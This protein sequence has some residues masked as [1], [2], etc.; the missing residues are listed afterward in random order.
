MKKLAHK[1]LKKAKAFLIQKITK[2]LKAL[3]LDDPK[4]L[5]KEETMALVKK[6]DLELYSSRHFWDSLEADEYV[7][8][9][10]ADLLD[11]P[12]EVNAEL[13]KMLQ[14]ASLKKSKVDL[15]EQMKAF[16]QKLYHDNTTKDNNLDEVKQDQKISNDSFFVTSLNADN[17]DTKKTKSKRKNADLYNESDDEDTAFPVHKKKNRP[18]QR[19]RRELWERQYGENAK[20]VKKLREERPQKSLRKPK[21]SIE[22]NS[23]KTKEK[24]HDLHPS[25]AAKLKQKQKLSE[26]CAENNR[27]V[28]D[29]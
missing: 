13:Y 26:A 28:F 29:E 5:K 3:P 18:G 20:H 1:A 19:A 6:I 9:R 8:A 23:V 2:S 16:L 7:R 10:I 11:S 24:V 12:Q 21:P 25:W 17:A 4:R 15:A 22:S 27:I 14:N